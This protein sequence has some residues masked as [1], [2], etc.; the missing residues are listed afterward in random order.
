MI[1]Q[2]FLFI[3]HIWTLIITNNQFIQIVYKEIKNNIVENNYFI[4]LFIYTY[5]IARKNKLKYLRK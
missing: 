4:A 2:L 3:R 1:I 5:I